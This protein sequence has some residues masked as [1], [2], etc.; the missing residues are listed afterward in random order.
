MKAQLDFHY[1]APEHFRVHALLENWGLYV[2]LTRASKP[3]PMWRFTRSNAR[4][5]SPP[6]IPIQIDTQ[7]GDA[8]EHVV[9]TLPTYHR[10]ALRWCYVERCAPA[11]VVRKLNVSYTTLFQLVSDA[12]ELVRHHMLSDHAKELNPK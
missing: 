4:S 7:E 5:W 8:M 1:V 6:E 12:R 10:T 9:A 11:K 3:A 2:R